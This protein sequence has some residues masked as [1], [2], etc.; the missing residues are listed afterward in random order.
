MRRDLRKH[1]CCVNVDVMY[2]SLHLHVAKP[3]SSV[4]PEVLNLSQMSPI[5]HMAIPE[6]RVQNI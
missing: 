6:D 3:L 5:L 1:W 2:P 4:H